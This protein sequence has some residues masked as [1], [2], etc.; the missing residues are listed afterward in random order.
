MAVKFSD[1]G[2]S[3]LNSTGFIVGYD[4]ATNLNI[5]IPK[6]TLDTTYQAILVSGTNIKTVNGTT[7]LGSGDVITQSAM[8]GILGGSTIAVGTAYL[9]PGASTSNATENNRSVSVG[10]GQVIFLYLKTA[11]TMTGSMAVT[12]MKNGV[13]T[14]MTFTIPLG[15]AA[16]KYSTNTNQ[17]TTVLG[18]ELSLR[19]VQST[20]TSS[21]VLSFGFIMQ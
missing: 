13:A 7:L 3:A 10:A 15:S 6:S 12:L 1:F 11:G 21:G 4:S 16:A 14:A 9:G 18:D 17:V 5:R 2:S 20:A 8:A 19:V